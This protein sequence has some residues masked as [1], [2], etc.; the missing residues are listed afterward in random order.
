MTRIDAKIIYQ[1]IKILYVDNNNLTGEFISRLCD[2]MDNQSI[3]EELYIR[4][5]N[6]NESDIISIATIIP[7]LSY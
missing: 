5:T 1:N 4:N 3:L 2:S 7:I 6:I